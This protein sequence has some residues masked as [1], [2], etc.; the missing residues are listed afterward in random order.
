MWRRSRFRRFR[1][2]LRGAPSALTRPPPL[3]LS[4]RHTF[5]PEKKSRNKNDGA[6]CEYHYGAKTGR[7]RKRKGEG[8][9]E[10]IFNLQIGTVSMRSTGTRRP[11]TRR[12]F[13]FT[14]VHSLVRTYTY[15]RHTR[16]FSAVVPRIRTRTASFIETNGTTA[17]EEEEVKEEK[18]EQRNGMAQGACQ[19]AGALTLY[20]H[21][22]RG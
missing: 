22:D 5:L 2:C 9:A 8:R 6:N 16:L 14:R 3:P 1:K 4:N 17:Q 21:R 11:Y 7:K 18:V 19:R 13:S 10:R 12:P 15:T 20:T